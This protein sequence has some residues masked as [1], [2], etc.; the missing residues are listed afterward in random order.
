MAGTKDKNKISKRRQ[1][2]KQQKAKKRKLRV[3][4]GGESEG[5]SGAGF[6]HVPEMPQME[7]PDGFRAISF[8][9]AIKE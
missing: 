1:K 7:P 6:E 8:S 5:G 9:Q 2:T 3:I 4:K